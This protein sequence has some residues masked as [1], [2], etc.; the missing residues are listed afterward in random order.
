MLKSP[1]QNQK[2]VPHDKQVGAGWKGGLQAGHQIMQ[3][4]IYL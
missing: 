4:G 2:L 3:V 1:K